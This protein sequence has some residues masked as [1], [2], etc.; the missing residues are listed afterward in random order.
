MRRQD[1]IRF[2]K[3]NCRAQALSTRLLLWVMAF[4]TLIATGCRARLPDTSSKSYADY[5]SAFYVGL[6]ALQVGD[7]VRADRELGRATQIVYGEPA[8]RANWGILALR[9]RNFDA[10]GD[11][12]GHARELANN[13]DQIYYLLG[14]VEAGRGKSGDAIEDLRKAVQINPNNLIATYRLAE[15]IE[16]QGDPNSDAEFQQLMQRMVAAQPNNMA[17]VIELG[18]V[19][20]KRGDA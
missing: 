13:N 3:K 6:A 10:A 18:R 11:R 8:G 17:A 1:E 16:R 19:A 9:Q 20:A 15:E 12:L 2:V 7:D 4:W 14:L 5:V